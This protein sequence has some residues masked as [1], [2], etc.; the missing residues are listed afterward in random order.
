MIANPGTMLSDGY[1]KHH[2]VAGLSCRNA[3]SFYTRVLTESKFLQR[4]DVGSTRQMLSGFGPVHDVVPGLSL[5][6]NPGLELANAFG[7]INAR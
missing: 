2:W 7:V 6:S 1:L 4:T 5:R 3:P